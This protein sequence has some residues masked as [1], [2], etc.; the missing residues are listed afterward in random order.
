L[1]ED[2][3]LY[4]GSYL[5]TEVIG[6]SMNYFYSVSA[7]K[8]INWT[9]RTKKS[10]PINA[11]HLLGADSAV[12]FATQ[13]GYVYS[14]DLNGKENWSYYIG[15]NIFS[16]IMNIDLNGNLYVC[17]SDSNL[18]SIK[19]NGELNWRKKHDNGFWGRS[20]V[21]SPDGQTLY[22][23]GVDSLLY[24][25]NLDGSIKWVF[26]CG[27]SPGLPAIDNEGNIYLVAYVDSMGLHSINPNGT[28]RWSYNYFHAERDEHSSPTISRNGDISF[29][30]GYTNPF[31][32][33]QLITVDYY[34]KFRWSYV[35]EEQL[36]EIRQ[37]LICDYNG[38]IYC[39]SRW[40]YYFYAI[41]SE[42]NLYWKYALDDY[43]VDNSVAI[44]SDGTLYIGTHKSSFDPN[45]KRT[46]IA[47]KDT[48]ITN[49][50]S[51]NKSSEYQLH[52]NYPN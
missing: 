51:E 36:E 24:A 35:F 6:D 17:A 26:D 38:T 50:N 44:G 40:G 43:A 33:S 39:G 47:I 22:I 46:L 32:Y 31:L 18:Y 28:L 12:Y 29:V 11:G 4:F 41:S 30:V 14:V 21:I 25:L 3:N 15:T 52:Q 19:N 16:Y 5:W 27:D 48:G 8:Q 20:V 9:F 10:L 7:E 49:V 34:G 37:P 45:Q 42:G 1:D 2:Q 13:G 23:T